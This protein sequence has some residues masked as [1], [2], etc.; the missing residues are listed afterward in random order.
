MWR[1]IVQ[2]TEV[3]KIEKT[4]QRKKTEKQKKK[5]FSNLGAALTKLKVENHPKSE[6]MLIS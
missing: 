4:D 1:N 5:R 6:K 2:T 3:L